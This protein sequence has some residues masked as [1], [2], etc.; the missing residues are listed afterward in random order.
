M[1]AKHGWL[2]LAP[3]RFTVSDCRPCLSAHFWEFTGDGHAWQSR[4]YASLEAAVWPCLQ[5]GKGSSGVRRSNLQLHKG[6]STAT[7]G[8]R[9]ELLRQQHYPCCNVVS[10]Q[11]SSALRVLI[12][13]LFCR[14]GLATGLWCGSAMLTWASECI[15]SSRC[16]CG[17]WWTTSS[18]FQCQHIM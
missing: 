6:A 8:K 13:L 14:F 7:K 3:T 11:R 18:V 17:Q 2:V 5:G 9:G 4:V 10:T 16:C 12:L 15:F 1:H